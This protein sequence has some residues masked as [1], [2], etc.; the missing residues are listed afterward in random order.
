MARRKVVEVTCDRCGRTETQAMDSV[1]DLPEGG[2]ELSVTLLGTKVEYT[3]L[4][5]RCRKSVAGYFK[6]LTMA[7]KDDEKGGEQTPANP[8]KIGLAGKVSR[9]LGG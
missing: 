2:V 5:R 4:C 7:P 9:A 8:P 3:D 1:P 6:Q